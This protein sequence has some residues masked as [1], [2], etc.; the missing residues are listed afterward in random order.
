MSPTSQGMAPALAKTAPWRGS[1]AAKACMALQAKA[2]AFTVP[3]KSQTSYDMPISS[4][5]R[6]PFNLKLH[7]VRPS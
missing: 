5:P 6:R 7:G 4:I 1:E 2:C 3:A